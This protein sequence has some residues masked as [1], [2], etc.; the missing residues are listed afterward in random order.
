VSPRA[1]VSGLAMMPVLYFKPPNEELHVSDP[2]DFGDF[3]QAQY[4]RVLALAAAIV[5]NRAEAEDIA[6][7]AFSRALGRWARL[8]DDYE[9][10]DAWVR[11]VAVRLAVDAHRRQWRIRRLFQRLTTYS[12]SDSE[13]LRENLSSTPVG[14]ALMRLPVRQREVWV[15][16]YVADLSVDTIAR[17]HKIPLGTVKDRLAAGRHRLG[18]ELQK[19]EARDGR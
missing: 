16:H 12:T 18:E 3:Y 14:E 17:E 8:R 11:C 4:R 1:N 6:Q 19:D 9:A 2:A 7:E 13:S 5:G 10:P 15:L